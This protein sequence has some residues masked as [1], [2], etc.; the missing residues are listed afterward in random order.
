MNQY[1]VYL[2][3]KD[4]EVICNFTVLAANREDALKQARDTLSTKGIEGGVI[5]L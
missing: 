2:K 1:T 5:T 4:G 3:T